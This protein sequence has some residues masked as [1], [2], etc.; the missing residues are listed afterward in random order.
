[1]EM[2]CEKCNRIIASD[3]CPHCKSWQVRTPAPGDICFLTEQG[4]VQSSILADILTRS[5]I[6]YV[7]KNRAIIGCSSITMGNR[8]FYVAYEQL[9]KARSLMESLFYSHEGEEAAPEETQK[10]GGD[11]LPFSPEEIDRLDLI[12]QEK[13]DLDELA[14]LKSRLT[15]TLK[16]MKIQ[17][18]LC[19]ARIDVVRDMIDETDYLIDDLSE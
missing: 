15:A 7:I 17:Q 19:Q 8:L 4:Y 10:G 2:Y 3:Q 9:E 18:R 5:G 16:E 1:M 14:R 13:M 12:M 11:S 6:P